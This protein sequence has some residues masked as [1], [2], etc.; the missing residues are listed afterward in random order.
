MGKRTTFTNET[1]PD[2]ARSKRQKLSN[3]A[4]DVAKS[5]ED[6]NSVDQL[7]SILTFHQDGGLNVRQSMSISFRNG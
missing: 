2:D 1:G 5:S 6:I 7:R 4:G 3:G